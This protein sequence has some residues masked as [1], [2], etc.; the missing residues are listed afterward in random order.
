MKKKNRGLP[1]EV[2]VQEEVFQGKTKATKKQVQNYAA[3]GENK[4]EN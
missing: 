1:Q 4:G 3:N 2:G